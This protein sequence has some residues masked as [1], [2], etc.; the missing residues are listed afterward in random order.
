LS[1]FFDAKDAAEVGLFDCDVLIS[2]VYP[3]VII[4]CGS[5]SLV[6][7]PKFF[8]VETILFFPSMLSVLLEY[9]DKID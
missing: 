8:V 9:F 3:G 6:V 4:F 2:F 7:L 5:F 1:G